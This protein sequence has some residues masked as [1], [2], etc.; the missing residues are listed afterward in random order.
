[1]KDN[2]NT[3]DNF[4]LNIN[5][6]KVQNSVTEPGFNFYGHTVVSLNGNI[7][8]DKRNQ[9]VPGDTSLATNGLKQYLADCMDTDSDKAINALFWSAGTVENTVHN[10]DLTQDIPD[11]TTPAGVPTIIGG[12]GIVIFEIDGPLGGLYAMRTTAATPTTDFGKKWRGEFKADAARSIRGAFIGHNIGSG[13]GTAS[14]S[15]ALNGGPFEVN[16]AR[17]T[18]QVVPM[19]QGDVLT[20]DW[21]I[22]IS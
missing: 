20:I 22:Y 6:N 3:S 13:A 17:Q 10:T 12:D 15:G 11:G 21:E 7:I 16:Y 18:F 4:S 19:V 9:I 2:F 8:E 14:G 5:G 1:M